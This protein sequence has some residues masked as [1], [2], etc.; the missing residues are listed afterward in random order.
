MESSAFA[1][2]P[3]P[4]GLILCPQTECCHFRCQLQTPIFFS[5]NNQTVSCRAPKQADNFPRGTRVA[6]KVLLFRIPST[7]EVERPPS[8]GRLKAVQTPP[9]STSSN[10]ANPA[11]HFCCFME[12]TCFPPGSDNKVSWIHWQTKSAHLKLHLVCKANQHLHL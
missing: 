2:S 9:S 7:A 1:F 11:P 6:T 12:I 10:Q 4:P 5:S 8:P 3:H